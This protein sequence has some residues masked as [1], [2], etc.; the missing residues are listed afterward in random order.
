MKFNKGKILGYCLAVLFCLC[1]A[2]PLAG[3]TADAADPKD[4]SGTVIYIDGSVHGAGNDL[5]DGTTPE[6]P[7]YHLK[8][9]LNLAGEGGTIRVLG[10]IYL[11]SEGDITLEN[12]TIKMDEAYS[13]TSPMIWAL[14]ETTLTLGTGA[15]IDGGNVGAGNDLMDSLIV[16]DDGATLNIHDGA[17]IQNGSNGALTVRGKNTVV[18]MDGGEIRDNNSTSKNTGVASAWIGN[19]ATFNLSGG[20]I[21]NNKSSADVGGVMSS[22]T[23]I[24]TG[25]TIEGN[26]S[27]DGGG[28]LM[29]Y[30]ASGETKLLGGEIKN[31]TAWYGGGVAVLSSDVLVDG[32]SIS[33]NT[34]TGNGG[35][36][37]VEGMNGTAASLTVKSGAV[38]DNESGGYG[39][40]IYAYY[41][42][43]D[44]VIDIQ[45]GTITGNTCEEE[46]AGDAIRIGGD[47][48]TDK[49]V[50]MNL[51]GTPTITGL[52]F[53]D[54]NDYA[55]TKMYVTGEFNPTSPIEVDDNYHEDYRPV[56]TYENGLTPDMSKF[57]P[58]DTRFLLYLDKQDISLVRPNTVTIREKDGSKVYGAF[59]NLPDKVI[60][61]SKMPEVKKAGYTLT[62]YVT[63]NGDDW[64]MMTD[65][66]E[67]QYLVLHPVWKLDPAT[68]TLTTDKDK[69]HVTPVEG[70]EA[71]LTAKVSPHAASNI[72]YTWQWY[73]GDKLIEEGKNNEVIKVNEPGTY[74]VVIVADHGYGTESDPAEKS[75]VIGAEDHSYP[76]KWESDETKHWKECTICGTKNSETEHSGGTATC[77]DQA[78][79]GICGAAYG[80]LDPQ[81]HAGGTTVLD[82]KEPT[83]T[84]EGYTGDTWCLGC[85]TKIADGQAVAAAGH[86]FGAWETVTSP[87]CT[88]G[89]SEKR[90]CAVCGLVETRGVDPA[91]HTWET[92]FTVDKEATCTQDGSKSIHCKKCDARKD[93]TVIPAAGH[94]FGAWEAVTSPDC[95]NAGSERRI[96]GVCGFVETRGVD[97]TGHTWET[98]FTVDKEATCTQDGSKSIHC[99]KCDARKDST[100]IPATGHSFGAWETVT[101]P[102]CTN[103]GIE[104]RICAKCGHEQ[105]RETDPTGH[106]WEDDFTVDKE[107]TCTQ[108]GV[109]SIHCEKCDAVKDETV[110]KAT[111]H[112]FGEWKIVKQATATEPGVREKVCSVCG[113]KVEEEIP[114][115]GGGIGS[116]TSHG[117]QAGGRGSSGASVSAGDKDAVAAQTGVNSNVAVWAAVM[118]LSALGGTAAVAVNRKAGSRRGRKRK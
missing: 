10:D 29:V 113:Y 100:A 3:M 49:Y 52:V 84:K 80:D 30:Y 58:G 101:L 34:A 88:N 1:L 67:K 4:G 105:T 87:N 116:G 89:S 106:T 114:V 78:E 75:I 95:T 60:D 22:G 64:N 111:G 12:I 76:D 25:G 112:S 72:T 82:K 77:K 110:I 26:V 32:T 90:T 51:S 57:T 38:N 59:Q 63:Q 66:V 56:I 93:S 73:K 55:T 14:K 40:G 31:N 104:K 48:E 23:F 96:C 5:N 8:R 65:L 86:R 107:P 37:Y 11:E 46:D 42:T 70:G 102:D 47:W 83:C 20:T 41:S 79:C 117:S 21:K 9:A 109:K 85:N 13:G 6:K 35:G 39:G 17:V 62:G 97:P 91:G 61:Q 68:F 18:N 24:M 94:S 118:L 92:D 81:N 33:G 50:R 15:V 98:D 44:T 99:E 43:T 19:G 108:D 27:G 2:L 74:R 54:V 16:L 36:F 69:V 71:T 7:V 115:A 103:A 45:G 53:L 28:G